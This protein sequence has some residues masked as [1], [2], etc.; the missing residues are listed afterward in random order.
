ML[1][2]FIAEN[3]ATVPPEKRPMKPMRHPSKSRR[4]FL[5]QWHLNQLAAAAH[6]E[7]ADGYFFGSVSCD[8]NSPSTGEG[9]VFVLNGV[10]IMTVNYR[11]VAN[12]RY[13][14]GKTFGS[15]TRFDLLCHSQSGFDS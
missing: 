13:S 12:R 11:T 15:Y 10:Q 7:N 6:K 2:D 1:L 4:S 9:I 8:Q 5:F 3:S 14:F